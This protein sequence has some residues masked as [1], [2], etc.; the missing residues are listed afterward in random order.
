[1]ENFFLYIIIYQSY[2][3]EKW[4]I[5]FESSNDSACF[6]KQYEYLL[7]EFILISGCYR[8]IKNN[9]IKYKN[10]NRVVG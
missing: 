1:M 7:Y 8:H 10:D 3:K 6:H 2:L 5:I 4:A 9:M